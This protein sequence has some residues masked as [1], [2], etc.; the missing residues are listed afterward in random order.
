MTTRPNDQPKGVHHSPLRLGTIESKAEQH[1]A[2]PFDSFQ[3]P[4]EIVKAYQ[5]Y[6][7]PPQYQPPPPPPPPLMKPHQVHEA[8]A[9]LP[10][11]PSAMT[12]PRVI[13]PLTDQPLIEGGQALFECRLQGHPLN[14][15]WFK[16]D[17][18]LKNQFRF[19]ISYDDKT[20][21]ARLFISTVFD[22]DAGKYTCRASNAIGDCSTNASLIPMVAEKPEVK[23]RAPLIEELSQRQRE[24]QRPSLSYPD[25]VFE[26]VK[27]APMEQVMSPARIIRG[28]KPEQ[29]KEDDTIV[30][31]ALFA[32]NP[33]PRVSWYKNNMPVIMSQR[34]TTHVDEVKKIC[35]LK[36]KNAK[37]DDSGVYTVVVENPFGSD[38]S[39]GPAMVVQPEPIHQTRQ[40]SVTRTPSISNPAE[41]S[42]QP[43]VKPPRIVKHLQPETNVNEGQPIILN[44]M[45]DAFPAPQ[46]KILQ[47]NQNH[48]GIEQL[49][50]NKH[51][52]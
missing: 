22:D 18:E 19:K 5:K 40:P 14:I 28:L 8:P 2:Q 50:I 17:T 51:L 45:I 41:P 34:H 23:Q 29:F 36:I 15:Q 6:P 38:H 42:P 24:K 31:K 20:G 48:N 3:K 21:M 30:L 39:S 1:Q 49:L 47:N 12:K 26:V 33:L 25:E 43:P 7:E 46:V 11:D 16:N 35:A 13:D 9:Q 44:C 10:I 37:T 27:G 32:G 4:V 52:F